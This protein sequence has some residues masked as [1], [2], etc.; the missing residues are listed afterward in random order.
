MNARQ[1]TEEQVMACPS[2][3]RLID[4]R[5]GDLPPAE[6]REI[7][8]HVRSCADCNADY[9]STRLMRA[10]LA[11]AEATAEQLD[12]FDPDAAHAEQ[13]LKMTRKRLAALCASEE[14]PGDEA[15]GHV[16]ACPFCRHRLLR[17]RGELD[18]EGRPA[19]ADRMA[20]DMLKAPLAR[21]RHKL[22]AAIPWVAAGRVVRFAAPLVAAADEMSRLLARGLEAIS[23]QPAP[24][25]ACVPVVLGSDMGVAAPPELRWDLPTDV[26]GVTFVALARQAEEGEEWEILCDLEGTE[27][28][29]LADQATMELLRDGESQFGQAPLRSAMS[30]WIRVEPGQWVIR[31]GAK[32]R[33]YEVALA[34]G[35]EP[36][37]ELG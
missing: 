9:E 34:L 3:E 13:C 24:V 8:D 10:A 6:K 25:P 1:E 5:S 28:A 23:P 15:Y 26:P 27:G 19:L 22:V 29:A 36:E 11:A 20:A 12:R 14:A 33:I 37:D 31:L 18:A 4:C 35:V 16:M 30:D 17:T 7:L 32:G 21:A 2:P